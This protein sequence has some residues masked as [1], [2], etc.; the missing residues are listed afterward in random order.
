[1]LTQVL[2]WNCSLCKLMQ[3][4][5]WNCSLTG[6][7]LELFTHTGAGLELFAHTGAG[8]ELF[9]SLRCWVGIVLHASPHK[10]YKLTQAV[11]MLG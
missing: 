1:M 3:V 2:G 9:G 10:P 5:G 8:L 11:L 4:L 7:G 6:A